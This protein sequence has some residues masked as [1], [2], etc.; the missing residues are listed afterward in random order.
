LGDLAVSTFTDN[1]DNLV[2]APM[3]LVRCS[4][5][6]LVQLKHTINQDYL[7][8]EHYWYQS[9]LNKSMIAAL[10][11][12]VI[13]IEQRIVLKPNDI[14]VD[15]GANDGTLLSQYSHCCLYKIAIDPAANVLEKAK[16]VCQ[17]THADYFK[18]E[19][20]G[21]RK[22]KVITSI[23]MIYDLEDPHKFVQD[24]ADVLDKDGIWIVQFG[25]LLNMI[26]T[27]GFD[28]ICAEHLE[29]YSFSVLKNI[30]EQHGL[31]VFDIQENDVNAGSLRLFISH[32]GV[33]KIESSVQQFLD[34]EKA[35][36]NKLYTFAQKVYQNKL[37]LKSLLEHLKSSGKT[38]ACI[39]AS[40]KGSTT[41]QYYDIGPDLIE[42]AGEVNPDKFGKLGVT[43]IPIIPESE[44][45]ARKPDY[46]LVLIWQFTDFIR[47]KYAGTGIKL[48]IPMP[49]LK[50]YEDPISKDV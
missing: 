38:V 40:T 32:A 1:L 50:I 34:L 9:G 28:T 6:E 4:D 33:R 3:L 43:G 23:A 20:L 12:I 17:E 19:L 8:K 37:D 14:V 18:K 7:Y 10:K 48:I 13:N 35:E 24:I 42:Y 5:C 21:S 44:L 2:K 16:K 26:R 11:D 39:G 27:N 29:Y 30:I 31:S 22:A 47:K 15:I 49:E 41:L 25:D 36:K 45:L 46:C